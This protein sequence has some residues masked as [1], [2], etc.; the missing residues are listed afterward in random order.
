MKRSRSD[1][2]IYFF[3]CVFVGAILFLLAQPYFEAQSFNRLTGGHAT[4]WDALW[5]ELRVDGS[6][7]V[8]RDKSE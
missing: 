3:L 8:L 7:Q 2:E 1:T 5:T 6:S 4:Y